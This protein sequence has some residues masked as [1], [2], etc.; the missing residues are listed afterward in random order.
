MFGHRAFEKFLRG[1]LRVLEFRRIQD[2]AHAGAIVVEWNDPPPAVDD[3]HHTSEGA[4]SP[5]FPSDPFIVGKERDLLQMSVVLFQIEFV[6]EKRIP[7]AR[8]N[9]VFRAQETALSSLLA[10]T[11]LR[12]LVI[13]FHRLDAGRL[14][15]LNAVLAG[16]VQQQLIEFRARDLVGTVGSRLKSVAKIKFNR[17]LTPSV[18][19]FS[20]KF[21]DEPGRQQFLVNAE[22]AK[23]RHTKGQERLADVKTGEFLALEYNHAASGFR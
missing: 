5:G 21:F 6:P 9:Q 10:H 20:T 7:T 18:C 12:T 13:E 22:P 15:N 16:M 17:L 4:V 19:H 3:A 2:N 11:Q 8:I 23:S 14:A 1:Q